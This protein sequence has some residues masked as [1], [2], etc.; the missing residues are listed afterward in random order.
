M[1]QTWTNLG[2]PLNQRYTNAYISA[3]TASSTSYVMVYDTGCYYGDTAEYS[4]PRIQST[5]APPIPQPVLE[6]EDE[7]CAYCWSL[8]EFEPKKKGTKGKE[9][10]RSTCVRCGAPKY[11][12][13]KKTSEMPFG[14][15]DKPYIDHC[16]YIDWEPAVE[17]A[18]L[19]LRRW[20]GL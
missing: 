7:Y 2:D 14:K 15:E 8:W 5:W 13:L 1:A 11:S 9:R 16:T 18:G 20:L 6:D 19:Q 3:T 4:A 17:P 10:K 12:A